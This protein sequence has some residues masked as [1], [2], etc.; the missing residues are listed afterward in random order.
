MAW[1]CRHHTRTTT[2]TRWRRGHYHPQKETPFSR[3]HVDY[4]GLALLLSPVHLSQ[5][6]GVFSTPILREVR[7]NVAWEGPWLRGYYDKS[8][9][10]VL[11]VVCMSLQKLRVVM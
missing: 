5:S 6:S 11:L 9:E 2:E 10:F 3:Y 1:P 4:T 8:T 7:E